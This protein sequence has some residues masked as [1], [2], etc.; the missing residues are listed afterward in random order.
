MR[1]ILEKTILDLIPKTGQFPLI[2]IRQV[3]SRLG[4]YPSIGE[5]QVAFDSLY[6]EGKVHPKQNLRR[7]IVGRVYRI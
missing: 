3:N 2:L 6:Q 7:T 4:R 5:M 1:K